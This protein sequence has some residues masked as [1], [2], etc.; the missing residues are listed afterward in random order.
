MNNKEYKQSD[1]YKIWVKDYNKKWY[2][3]NRQHKV[4]QSKT[5]RKII[6][7]FVDNIKTNKGCV[8]CGFNTH[9][10][11]LDFHHPNK[12]KDFSVSSKYGQTSINTLTEEIKKC[13]VLCANCHRLVHAGI[14]NI[15]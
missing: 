10:S 7:E 11:A 12:D 4:N 1:K 3:D 15:N 8:K 6:R 13:I 2:N 5:Y 14:L 9:P